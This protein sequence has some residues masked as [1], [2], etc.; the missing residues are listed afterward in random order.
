MGG[1]P[2]F[3]LMAIFG[4][5]VGA[6]MAA[7]NHPLG[8]WETADLAAGLMRVFGGIVIGEA[9]AIL[10]FALSWRLRRVT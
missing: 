10:A 7:V 3:L 1:R 9:V 2:A 5:L 4:A 8:W 6:Y